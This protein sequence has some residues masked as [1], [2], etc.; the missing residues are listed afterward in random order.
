MNPLLFWF[1]LN[2]H[3]DCLYHCLV[4]M[5]AWYSK[6]PCTL[7]EP[8]T[9]CS[10]P[11]ASL[12]LPIDTAHTAAHGRMQSQHKVQTRRIST[13]HD[14]SALAAVSQKPAN[15][16]SSFELALSTPHSVPPSSPSP[17][18]KA[19]PPQQPTRNKGDTLVPHQPG[20]FS[21]L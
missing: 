9:L 3:T 14:S 20:L 8:C 12:T 17:D 2:R 6:L 10:P 18:S 7:H 11:L 4:T 5:H 15:T 16:S 1:A 19:L 13:R 21:S